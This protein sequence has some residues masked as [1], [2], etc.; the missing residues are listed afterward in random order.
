MNKMSYVWCKRTVG[1]AFHLEE[2]LVVKSKGHLKIIMSLAWGLCSI[3]P[4]S[5][6]FPRMK[7][8]RGRI[9]KEPNRVGTEVGGINWHVEGVRKKKVGLEEMQGVKGASYGRV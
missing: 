1:S 3:R 7:L 5:H 9:T 2:Q 6:G 8:S 4:L